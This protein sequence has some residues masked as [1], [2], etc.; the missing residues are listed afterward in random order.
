M[1]DLR[2]KPQAIDP[3]LWLRFRAVIAD[4]DGVV[5]RT[6]AIHR[7]A[8]KGVFDELLQ[9][10]RERGEAVFDPFNPGTDYPSIDGIPRLDGVRVFLES[11]R[12][13]LDEGREGDSLSD[14]T[15]VGIGARKNEI[16][17]D[18]LTQRGVPVYRSAL[19]LLRRLRDRGIPLAVVSSSRNC[20]FVL[21]NAHIDGLFEVRID[22]KTLDER[23]LKG[24]PAPDLFAEAARALGVEP[25]DA[26]AIE[27]APSGVESAARAG[28]GFVLGIARDGD[29]ASE[30][31]RQRGAHAVVLSLDGLAPPRETCDVASLPDAL[32][33]FDRICEA[34]AG[35][36]PAV[37]LDYDGTLT[38][39]VDRPEDAVLSDGMREAI[40]ALTGRALVAVISGRGLDDVRARVDVPG[41][42]Y[43]G[44]HGFEILDPD[45]EDRSP[46]IGDRYAPSLERGASMLEEALADIEGVLV[47]RKKFAIAVHYR[48]AGEEAAE[49]VERVCHE[50][51]E[52]LG[53]L[54]VTGGKMIAELRADV[55][56][57]KGSAVESI[58]DRA[59]EP[60][61]HLLPIYLGDDDTDED[62]FVGAADLGGFGITVGGRERSTARYRLGDPDAVRAWLE[63]FAEILDE[64]VAP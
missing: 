20:R 54:R 10:R 49:R 38:P 53:D 36:R 2:A 42:W 17:H 40:R 25:G 14:E 37:L 50:T 8:W 6:A 60:E 58:I 30:T 48:L 24:K 32:D 39:I 3:S 5:T 11:R 51:A 31:L 47:E 15:V 41:L 59:P 57:H 13:E 43:A 23:G 1:E 18:L 56:W 55:D 61:T 44:S 46:G 62:A 12:L 19:R 52:A 7:D 64:E 63:R 16:Y 35:R 29:D 22:G 45:G 21:D 27:D 4:L 33:T 34:C 26:A 9:L 28:C